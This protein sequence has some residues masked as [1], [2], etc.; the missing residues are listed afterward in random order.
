MPTPTPPPSA[1]PAVTPAPA[2]PETP[3]PSTSETPS[4]VPTPS[5]SATSTPEPDGGAGPTTTPSASPVALAP[6]ATPELTATAFTPA[7][8]FGGFGGLFGAF[9]DGFAFALSAAIGV[10][11]LLFM[12]VVA[13]QVLGAAAWIPTIRRSLAGVGLA[14]RRRTSG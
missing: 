4:P 1:A 7:G 10:P 8:D 14:R 12:L 9:G 3:S 11:G 6:L 13:V 2:D 5:A